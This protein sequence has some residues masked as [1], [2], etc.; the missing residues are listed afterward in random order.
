MRT[1][2]LVL[3]Q[4]CIITCP[5][6]CASLCLAYHKKTET[7]EVCYSSRIDFFIC[8][9]FLILK[10]IFKRTVNKKC[11]FLFSTHFPFNMLRNLTAT[12]ASHK[13]GCT[14]AYWNKIQCLT[15]TNSFSSLHQL[16]KSYTVTN[17]AK[18][19][20]SL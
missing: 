9:I 8:M 3:I 10:V 2:G 15:L 18:C 12:M 13:G 14:F 4:R 20:Q 11:I 16:G 7:I 6:C 1:A 19:S 17:D 5:W